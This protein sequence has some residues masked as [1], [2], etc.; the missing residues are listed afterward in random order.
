MA[1]TYGKGVFVSTD[2]GVS[3]TSAN[4]GVDTLKAQHL[5]IAPDGDVY[6][7]TETGVFRSTDD[8]ALW[9][10]ISPNWNA[11]VH[12]VGVTHAGALFAAT[13]RGVYRTTDKGG[14]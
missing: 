1:G 11:A 9:T 12:K 7:G 2:K 10:R 6:L 14:S 3:W 8:G 13:H 5:A 4:A